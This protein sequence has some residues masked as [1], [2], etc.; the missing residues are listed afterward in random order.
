MGSDG[1]GHARALLTTATNMNSIK[2]IPLTRDT[3]LLEQTP[4]LSC[5]AI[6]RVEVDGREGV[7]TSLNQ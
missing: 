6:R 3:L 4:S 1:G 7:V 5:I 2:D